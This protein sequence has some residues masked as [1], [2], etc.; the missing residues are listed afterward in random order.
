MIFTG[1][2]IFCDTQ[3]ILYFASNARC[4]PQLLYNTL[5]KKQKKEQ[6]EKDRQ[7]RLE[8]ARAQKEA[9]ARARQEEATRQKM[10]AVRTR[11]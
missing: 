9:E 5:M 6:E 7:E 1:L 2:M 3:K 10:Q 8:A 4:V 11:E